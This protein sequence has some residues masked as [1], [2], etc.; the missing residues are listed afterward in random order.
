MY[1]IPES[2]GST[3]RP[4][5]LKNTLENRPGSYLE[6][7]S[8]QTSL[9]GFVALIGCLTLTMAGCDRD[10]SEVQLQVVPNA[11]CAPLHVELIGKARVKQGLKVDFRWTI[12]PETVLQGQQAEHTFDAPGKHHIMLTVVGESAQKTKTTT[13]TVRQAEFPTVA[14]L[15][16]LTQCTYEPLA[17]VEEEK[18][19]K[20]LGRTTL[21]DLEKNIV[22]RPL[23]TSELVTHPLW[24]RE[25][26]HTV[27]M[28]AREQF[29]SLPREHFNAHGFV[30]VGEGFDQVALFS[31][32]QATSVPNYEVK[33]VTR[34]IDNWGINNIN[35]EQHKLQRERLADNVFR[36]VPD[37]HLSG[38]RYF[39]DVK[40][41][42]KDTSR[43]S[44]IALADSGN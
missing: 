1:I 21:E 38:G 42:G 10:I 12:A 7:L 22:G 11:G 44:P 34:L 43:I 9:T 6:M 30:A 24:R 40:R 18:M 5:A 3:L 28:V 17:E 8:M 41:K 39:I 37:I 36:Y 20:E 15:Y 35:P 25:H 27:Y 4:C 14:G 33:I 31:M 29:V 19:V 2:G 32:P 16:I 13:I 26:T 23:A